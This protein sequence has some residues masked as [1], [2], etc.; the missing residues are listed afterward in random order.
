VTATS[1]AAELRECAG[2][3]R[4]SGTAILRATSELNIP[5]GEEVLAT[6]CESAL[7]TGLGSYQLRYEPARVAE[8]LRPKPAPE[9]TSFTGT[10]TVDDAGRV[11]AVSMRMA[12]ESGDNHIETTLS[13]SDFGAPVRIEPPDQAVDYDDYVTEVF[14]D[15]LPEGLIR[16]ED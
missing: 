13:F 8:C 2:R 1:A 4:A 5:G 16:E 6:G 11:T 12:S 15:P 14:G 7:A 3:T 9:W 10:A